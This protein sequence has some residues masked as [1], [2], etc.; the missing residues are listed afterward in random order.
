MITVYTKYM[1]V[2][3]AGNV[4]S[5]AQIYGEKARKQIALY[6]EE[7]RP[8]FLL[9]TMQNYLNASKPKSML[10]LQNLHPW[11]DNKLLFSQDVI[12]NDGTLI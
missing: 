4:N 12:R 2:Y 1:T 5:L 11:L 9:V 6:C 3:L 7:L 10:N 8:L